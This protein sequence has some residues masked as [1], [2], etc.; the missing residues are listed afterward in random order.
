MVAEIDP[1]ATT[2]LM[3]TFL[4]GQGW[5]ASP[6]LA[7]DSNGAV[8]VSG[9][10]Q[11]LDFPVTQSAFQTAW[12]GQTDAFVTKI[13]PTT[14]A[15]AV[16][17]V[18]YS[19]QFASQIVGSTSAPQTTMLRNMGSAALTISSKTVSGDFAET[20]DCGGT[21]AAA[22]FCTFTISFTPAATGNRTGTLTIVD[23]AQGSPHVVTLAGTGTGAALQSVSVSPSSL[24]F[25]SSSV[26]T[27]S[28]AQ[29]ITFANTSGAAVV[30][31]GIQVTGDFTAASNSC[32]TVAPQGTCSVRV[33][34]I[35]ASPGPLTGT[36]QFLD[37]ASGS[38]QVVTLSGSGTDF[39]TSPVISQATVS[40]GG[41][42]T[43]KLSI[44]PTGGAFF[45]LVTFACNGAPAF[46]RCTVNPSSTTPGSSKS[47]EVTVAVT[48][49]GPAS[50]SQG[51]SGRW[52]GVSAALLCAPM[53]IFGALVFAP[54]RRRKV[55]IYTV[56]AVVVMLLLV[57][58][59]GTSVP[60][61]PAVSRTTPPGT[62]SLSVVATS[63]TL[64]HVTKLTL[65][66]Q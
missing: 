19:L 36:L 51:I 21:V 48:T 6:T 2:L 30:V 43:Y 11:S 65:T 41:T 62:Y 33:G 35:P 37:S 58:C 40:P 38:P 18:P 46:A 32:G 59:G 20:D 22:S 47:N 4:G 42:A 64:Q 60:Q 8:Y 50:K 27:A 53:A 3:A 49:S 10:T 63:G 15:P 5:E 44:S 61:S 13:D 12:G 56:S 54:N 17:M 26:G 14:N 24:N 1:G 52:R 25:P 23:N 9:E 66:V 29:V 39:V 55:C 45:N 57:G 16:A 34:F 7:L 31:S 28:A